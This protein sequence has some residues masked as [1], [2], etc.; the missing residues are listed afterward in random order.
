MASGKWDTHCIDCAEIAQQATEAGSTK[1]R[2]TM[3]L[4]D[5]IERESEGED[6]TIIFSQFTTML[7]LIEPFLTKKGIRY[8][9][10]TSH[11]T[12]NACDI[13]VFW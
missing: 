11:F 3:E 6:K 1:I 4:L 5:D 10:C 2:K 13:D 9:R 8:A 7:D 12:V